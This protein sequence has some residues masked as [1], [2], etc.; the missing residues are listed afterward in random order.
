MATQLEVLALALAVPSVAPTSAVLRLASTW[1]PTLAP[2]ALAL[3]TSTLSLATDTK[4][5]DQGSLCC[6]NV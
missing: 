2:E 3:E 1:L 6:T 5:T 4:I